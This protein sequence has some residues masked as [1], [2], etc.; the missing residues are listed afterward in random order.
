MK[1]KDYK[2]GKL[3]TLSRPFDDRSKVLFL[4]YFIAFFFG[5]SIF[6]WTLLN[7]IMP[8][9]ITLFLFAIVV[10]FYFAAYRFLKRT[11]MTEKLFVNSNDL[12]IIKKGIISKNIATFKISKISNFRHLDK[13]ELTKHPLAGQTIDY[14]GFQTEQQVINEM[15]G[16]NRIAFDYEGRTISF[17]NNIYTWQFEELEILIYDVTKNDLRFNDETEK[18]LSSRK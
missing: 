5:G 12:S 10:I 3:I 18:K 16:D 13:P 6:F 9:G 8:G 2:G 1:I 4:I 7:E 15:H 14:L 11:L 17:G